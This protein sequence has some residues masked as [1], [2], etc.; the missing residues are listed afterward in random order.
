MEIIAWLHSLGLERYA[1]AFRANDIDLHI[2]PQLTAE[3]LTDLGVV[4]VGHRRKCSAPPRR[5]ALDHPRL[6]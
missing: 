6:A 2:L 5:F 1:A 4:S 3:D